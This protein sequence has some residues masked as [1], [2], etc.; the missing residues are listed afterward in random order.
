MGHDIK[1]SIIEISREQILELY[2]A[3]PEAVIFFVENIKE[4]INNLAQKI[5][6]QEKVI[7]QLNKRINYLEGIIN[8]DIHNSNK[9]PSSDGLK[10]SKNK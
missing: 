5:E 7:E 3:G 10:K 4:L 8:K 1:K 9:P 2:K 6:G